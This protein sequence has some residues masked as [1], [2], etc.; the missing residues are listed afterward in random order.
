MV[1]TGWFLVNILA[2]LFLPMLGILP[3]KLLHLPVPASRLRLM[4]TVKDGQLCW[5][6][7]GISASAIYELWCAATSQVHMPA[8]SGAALA[9]TVF[10][11][12]LSMVVAGGGAVFTT[13]APSVPAAGLRAWMR[14]HKVLVPSAAMAGFAAYIVTELHFAL[15]R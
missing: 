6:A 14:D 10:N 3:L 7:I 9:A 11:M 4:A 1:F 12:L 2:P 13:P 15:A 5:A 8:W